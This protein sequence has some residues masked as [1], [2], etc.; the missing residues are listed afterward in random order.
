MY[1]PLV[2]LFYL[3]LFTMSNLLS[4][5]YKRG[6]HEG[7]RPLHAMGTHLFEPLTHARDLETW[8]PR[9]LSRTFVISTT[10]LSAGAR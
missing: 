1:S 2:I 3:F 6:W 9:S 4:F 7:G 8:E 10:N 5:A